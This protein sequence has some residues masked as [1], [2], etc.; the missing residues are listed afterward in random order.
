[1]FARRLAQRLDSDGNFVC[2]KPLCT[3]HYR[4]HDL[5]GV[6]PIKADASI[7]AWSYGCT[8][9]ELVTMG[10]YLMAGPA[11]NAAERACNLRVDV[12]KGTCE[13][14]AQSWTVK[15]SSTLMG[16][17]PVRRSARARECFRTIVWQ[18]CAPK[19]RRPETLLSLVSKAL[20]AQ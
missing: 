5:W 13:K 3:A 17:F 4:A 20:Q 10:G 15:P 12:L 11:T 19:G 16:S 2:R 9:Y 7:D 6:M 14:W 1:M 18:V 8:L